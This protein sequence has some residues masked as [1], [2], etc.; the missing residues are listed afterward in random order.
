M[1]CN[2]FRAGGVPRLLS[3]VCHAGS[4]VKGIWIL[5][6]GLLCVQQLPCEREVAGVLDVKNGVVQLLERVR[7]D[8]GL[9][10]KE[11]FRGSSF[12]TLWARL[13][14]RMVAGG[15]ICVADAVDN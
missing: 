1:L 10:S 4:I 9:H 8:V 14:V 12:T 3:G 11:G 7:T 13:A 15:A 6:L 2:I 5:R